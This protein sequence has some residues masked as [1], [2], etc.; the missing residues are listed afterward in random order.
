VNFNFEVEVSTLVVWQPQALELRA[1]S[2]GIK[3]TGGK[4]TGKELLL[5]ITQA[6]GPTYMTRKAVRAI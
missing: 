2:S 3:T 6:A 5:F 4:P 1:E